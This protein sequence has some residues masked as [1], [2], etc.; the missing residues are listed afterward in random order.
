VSLIGRCIGES[1]EFQNIQ[2]SIVAGCAL[3]KVK[4]FH[5]YG[6]VLMGSCTGES[7]DFQ[8]IKGVFHKII[9]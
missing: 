1:V 6:A 5:S 8:Q 7:D 2:R 9:S 4:T 3:V